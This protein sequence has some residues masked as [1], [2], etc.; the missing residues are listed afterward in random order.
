MK[1]LALI[2][3]TAFVV[4]V[5]F[6][7]CQKENDDI[8]KNESLLRFTN[9]KP[10]IDDVNQTP[11]T[12]DAAGIYSKYL[13]MCLKYTG[14]NASHEFI[15]SWDGIVQTVDDKKFID[16]KVY[17]KNVV[18]NG[19]SEVYDSLMLNMDVLN[20]SEELL[21]D[22]SV[23]FNVINTSNLSNVKVIQAYIPDGGNTDPGDNTDPNEFKDIVVD[24]VEQGTCTNG[25]W[26]SLWLKNSSKDIYYSPKSIDGSITY[27]PTLNDRLK[28]S[29][30][31]TWYSDSTYVCPAWQNKSVEVINIKSIEK[32]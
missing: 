26:G 25:T 12:I 1:K 13:Y 5:F 30:E 27:T 22:K 3:L 15:V 24:V 14:G 7:A 23:Y 28:I 6:A 11:F 19:T 18:D 32:Q 16:L 10:S 29:F 8:Q 20:I 9:S 21:N 4:G 31:R 2:V 17:H